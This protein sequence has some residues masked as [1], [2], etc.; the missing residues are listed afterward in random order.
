MILTG[1]YIYKFKKKEFMQ[2]MKEKNEEIE[3]MVK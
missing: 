3:N 1:V 2:Y